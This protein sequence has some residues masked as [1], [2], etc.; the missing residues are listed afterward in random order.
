MNPKDGRKIFE[1]EKGNPIV[2]YFRPCA[3]RSKIQPIVEVYYFD[4]IFSLD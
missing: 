2:F 1:D 3:T 4:M